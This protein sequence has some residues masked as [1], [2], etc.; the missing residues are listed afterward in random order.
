MM[1]LAAATNPGPFAERT[2]EMG[3]FHG[4]L[5]DGRLV[6]M[7]G[8]R[9]HAGHLREVSGIC[10]APDR[11]GRGLATR[12]TNLVIR[13]QLAR[14]QTPFLHVASS[15]VRARQLYEHLGFE[16]DRE[17]ALRIIYRE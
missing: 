15:N 6:A 5:E 1:A 3:D 9:M 4:V 11:R 14:G 12:L 8:E 13:L 2:F 10:T 7:A 17:V 16:V